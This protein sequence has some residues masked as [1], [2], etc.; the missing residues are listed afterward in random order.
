MAAAFVVGV[1]HP[2]AIGELIEMAKELDGFLDVHEYKN[3]NMVAF[4]FRDVE[5]AERA[6]WIIEAN[7]KYGEDGG[8]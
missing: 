7:G 4:M 3:K 1:R 6:K 2:E 8:E 5:S